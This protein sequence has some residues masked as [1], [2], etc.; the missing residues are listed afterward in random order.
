MNSI[1]A[2]MPCVVI[3]GG[4]FGG[5]AAAKKLRR[6]PV[7]VILIDRTNHHLFQPL[8]YQ[9]ATSLLT[10]G[11]IGWP[12]RNILRRQK[13]ATVILGDVTHVNVEKRYVDDS[14]ADRRDVSIPY[15][16]LILA[17]GARQSYFGHDEFERFAPGLKTLDDVTMRN[18]IPAFEQAEA[19]EDPSRHRDLLTLCSSAAGR[20]GWPA[21]WR[22]W[23]LCA[24]SSAH[25]P[26]SARIVL[27]DARGRACSA[28]SPRL[29]G[30]GES[31]ARTARRGGAVGPWRRTH[32]RGGRHRRG[33][34]DRQQDGHLDRRRGAV[35]RREVVGRRDGSGGPRRG[36]HRPECPGASGD[37]R[38]R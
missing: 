11:Q 21:R 22:C 27:I 10:P 36:E 25:R 14:S 18:H 17:T 29:L 31:A 37:L 35:S 7:E 2:R 19:E 23:C 20:R 6:T 13:N 3:V 9:V 34:T 16:Y 8:L 4:G 30:G 1:P 5:L 38:D 12:I 15:D 33:R 32:R 28:R 24:L 26:A